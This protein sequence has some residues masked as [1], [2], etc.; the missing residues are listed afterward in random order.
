MSAMVS[1]LVPRLLASC[2]P[3]RGTCQPPMPSWTR[4]E[5]GTLGR[6]VAQYQGVVC[7]RS[8]RSFSWMSMWRSKWMMPIR[9]DVHCAMP[10]MQGKPIE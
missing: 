7:M 9:F 3:S 1:T 6:L 2:T 10:R 5:A 8:S 4:F